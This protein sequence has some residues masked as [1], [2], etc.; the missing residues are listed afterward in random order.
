MDVGD[1]DVIEAPGPERADDLERNTDPGDLGLPVATARARVGAGCELGQ[2][3]L[4][5]VDSTSL[6]A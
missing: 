1:L 3:R 6:Q 5:S 2:D 4:G